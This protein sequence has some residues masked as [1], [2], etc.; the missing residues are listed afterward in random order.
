MPGHRKFDRYADSLTRHAT[1]GVIVRRVCPLTPD[2]SG[3]TTPH[4]YLSGA[5]NRGGNLSWGLL[6]GHTRAEPSGDQ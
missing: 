2:I 4:Q 3:Q 1:D 5:V 6:S